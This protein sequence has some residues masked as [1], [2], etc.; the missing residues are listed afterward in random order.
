[1]ENLKD[2]PAATSANHEEKPSALETK[3]EEDSDE[4]EEM[5]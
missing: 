2:V 1:M 3:D 4:E 5:P